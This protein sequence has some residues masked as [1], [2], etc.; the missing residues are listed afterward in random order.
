MEPP[1][2]FLS[3]SYDC[4]KHEKWVLKLGTKLRE[5]GVD[6]TLDKWELGLGDLMPPF[7]REGITDS[8]RVLIICTDTYVEKADALKD[9]VGYEMTIVD[10]ELD[11]NLR[12]NKFIPIIRQASG[13]P[14]IPTCLGKRWHIDFRNDNEF[15]EKFDVLLREIQGDP[16]NPKP[17]LGKYSSAN[18]PSE[19]EASSH[20]LSN[21]SKKVESASDAY[22]AA[23]AFI[24]SEN[25]FGGDNL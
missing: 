4:D 11:Q 5:K 12:T 16:I 7:M 18:Q 8:D 19:P 24:E 23:G 10:T 14:K 25:R 2:V 15:D 9:G 22:K 21:I 17:P 13:E 1:K 20:Y 6:A 3:Y